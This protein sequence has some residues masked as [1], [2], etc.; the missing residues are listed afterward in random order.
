MKCK[1]GKTVSISV[2]LSHI[3]TFVRHPPQSCLMPMPMPNHHSPSRKIHPSIPQ[4][5]VYVELKKEC[6]ES[7]NGTSQK[8]HGICRIEFLALLSNRS[9]STKKREW[10]NVSKGKTSIRYKAVC[11][12]E[13][14]EEQMRPRWTLMETAVQRSKRKLVYFSFDRPPKCAR[15][16]EKPTEWIDVGNKDQPMTASTSSRLLL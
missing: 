7:T 8:C 2:Y 16:P 10:Y 11:K 5:N 14:R 4:T 15:N 9:Q 12:Q 1:V 6:I 3:T 13:S